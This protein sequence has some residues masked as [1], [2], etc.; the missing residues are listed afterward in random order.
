MASDLLGQQPLVVLAGI[1]G[2][3]SDMQLL[4]PPGQQ[5][6]TLVLIDR[7]AGHGDGGGRVLDGL[8]EQG[9]AE[10]LG[11]WQDTGRA[12]AGGAGPGGSRR[13][14]GPLPA[15]WYSATLAKEMRTSRRSSASVMP[16]ALARV[17][18]R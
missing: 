3:V 17:R 15:F 7:R 6:H 16:A 9:G 18:Y 12:A 13:G 10:L 2:E 11:R 5:G 1:A 8:L 14:S 4:A